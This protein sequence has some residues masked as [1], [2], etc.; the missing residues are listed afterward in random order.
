MVWVNLD[1]KFPEHPNNDALSDAAFRLQVA[2]ICYANRLRTDG[3]IPTDR[4]QRLVPR[5]RKATL[6]ELLTKHTWERNGDGGYVIRDYL[7]WNKTREEIETEQERIRKMRSDAGKK[8][9][10]KRWQ[11]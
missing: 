1:D 11:T 7:D 3:H 8:G 10:A 5:F 9:A 4:P 2:A 6:D